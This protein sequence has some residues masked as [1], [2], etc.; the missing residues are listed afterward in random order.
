MILCWYSVDC[1]GDVDCIHAIVSVCQ[2][3]WPSI[4]ADAELQKTFMKM[5]LFLTNNSLPGKFYKYE[6][7]ELK[8]RNQLIG[9]HF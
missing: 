6:K 4:G 9:F 7:F 8:I 3:F 5:L 1:L 2:K